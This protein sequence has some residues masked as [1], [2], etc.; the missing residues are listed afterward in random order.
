MNTEQCLRMMTAMKS[1]CQSDAVFWAGVAEL[2]K[3]GREVSF[4]ASATDAVFWGAV[5]SAASAVSSD[6]SA[7]SSDAEDPIAPSP[8]EGAMRSSL[9]PT[10]PGEVGWTEP[11]KAKKGKKAP[12]SASASASESESAPEPKRSKAEAEPTPKLKVQ[13][14]TQKAW[15][16]L[17]GDTVKEMGTSGWTAWTD[18]KGAL[19]PA[20][21]LNAEGQYVYPSGQYAGKTASHQRGGMARASYIKTHVMGLQGE[22]AELEK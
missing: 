19:W 20:S 6:A 8:T 5:S 11:K 17:V 21:E 12:A 4:A 18:A 15:L 10:G 22:W 9:T 1:A 3:S 13:S 14:D 2:R 7:V 16:T